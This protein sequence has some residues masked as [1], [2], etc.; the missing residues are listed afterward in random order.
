[1]GKS[2]FSVVRIVT[3]IIRGYDFCQGSQYM[4]DLRFLWQQTERMADMDMTGYKNM[5]PIARS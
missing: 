1:M 3:S 2:D 4:T 5:Y